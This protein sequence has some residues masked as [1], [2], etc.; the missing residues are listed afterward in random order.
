MNKLLCIL[1]LVA[2]SAMAGT[3]QPPTVQSVSSVMES[4]INTRV[5]TTVG[6]GY[7][8]DAQP[9]NLLYLASGEGIL[10]SIEYTSEGSFD[11]GLDARTNRSIRIYADGG[12]INFGGVNLSL[13]AGNLVADIPLYAPMCCKFW[14]GF[15][16]NWLGPLSYGTRYVGW[17]EVS[18]SQTFQSA[19]GSSHYTVTLRY[20]MPFT[21]GI[22]VV[23]WD[24]LLGAPTNRG[25]SFVNYELGSV[26]TALRGYR[27]RAYH[28]ISNTVA[29]FPVI[30][31]WPNAG[32]VAS[33]YLT[34]S[35]ANANNFFFEGL[36]NMKPEGGATVPF[37]C[38]GGEDL[39]NNGF[40]L[41][42]GAVSTWDW[43]TRYIH[44]VTGENYVTECYRHFSGADSTRWTTSQLIWFEPASTVNWDSTV[45]FYGK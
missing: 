41:D 3:I 35:S 29:N 42:S 16:T 30:L 12:T 20:P 27:L 24:T 39:F 23:L 1:L 31:N 26:P 19:Q 7:K 9:T 33:V 40:F 11:I 2:S 8:N 15:R 34:G 32:E 37:G 44:L 25:F 18:G 14:P 45:I 13:P 5:G 36:W 6:V 10:R 4:L 38:A 43:G 22:A 28:T 21:N 17:S